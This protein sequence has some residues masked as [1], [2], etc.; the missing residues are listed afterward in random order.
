MISDLTRPFRITTFVL[1]TTLTLVAACATSNN[2]P[3][4]IRLL[5]HKDFELPEAALREFTDSTGIEVLVFLEEDSTSMVDLLERSKENPVAD[6]VLGVDSLERR[7]VTEQ[8]LVEPYQPIAVDRLD[9]SLVLQDEMLTPVSQLAACLN[10]SKSRYQVPERLLEKLPNEDVASLRAPTKF[11]DLFDPRHAKTAVIPDPLSSRLGIY[12]LVALERLHPEDVEGITPWP[13]LLDEMLRWGLEVAPTW[14]EAWFSRFQ[15]SSG[16]E[17]T[18]TRSLTWGSS[19]MPTVSVRFVPELPDEVDVTVVDSGCVKV[20]NY[21]GVIKNTPNRRDA[22]RLVDSF[23]E[24]LF[25]YN[26]SDRYGSRPA[27][28]DIVRT[29]AWRRFGV[30]VTAIPIDEWRIGPLWQQWLLTWQQVADIVK[31]GEDPLPPV[32]QVTL[33]SQ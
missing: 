19:G 28:T 7:R 17:N 29:E 14:E 33:P 9:S 25:Q 2:D 26:V 18:D 32:V 4:T 21:A 30:N 1:V 3:A 10:R 23:V 16:P 13:K 27:R 12:F 22:G 6:V 24:P 15:P 31:S 11:S 8:K 5:T 20:V